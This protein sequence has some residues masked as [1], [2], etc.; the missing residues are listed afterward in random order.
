MLF[1]I[2]KYNI[3][4]FSI[5]ELKTWD[6]KKLKEIS[7]KINLY[8]DKQ[9]F[10]RR[11]KASKNIILSDKIS[12]KIEGSENQNIFNKSI[13]D[14]PDDARSLLGYFKKLQVK[15]TIKIENKSSKIKSKCKEPKSVRLIYT[16]MGNKR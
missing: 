13:N 5:D 10:K 3:E 12:E 9:T 14:L 1:R 15:N 2:E 4:I 16:P 6:I 7:S 8:I 11:L